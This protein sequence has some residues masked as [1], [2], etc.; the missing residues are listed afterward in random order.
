M[1]QYRR[2]DMISKPCI[3]FALCGSFC[4]FKS[5]IAEMER[6]HEAGYELY[7]ILSEHAASTDTRFG[8]AADFRE[9]IEK[10]CGRPAITT[11]TQVEELGPKKLIDAIVVAPC[12]GSTLG[13]LAN[14]ISDTA[15]TFAVKGCLR[16]DKPVVI[17]LSTNDALGASAANIGALLARRGVYFVPFAQDDPENKP[18]S[19]VSDVRLIPAAVE[20]ALE[21]RQI[22]PILL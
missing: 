14:G 7:P 22:Q 2:K 5:V 20:K 17:A 21:G 8:D 16:N 19:A 1:K 9:K 18:R 10:I 4:T 11:F 13:K 15:V 6:M 3:G 12:T